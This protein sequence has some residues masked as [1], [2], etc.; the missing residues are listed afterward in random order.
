MTDTETINL[1]LLISG[2]IVDSLFVDSYRANKYN[3]KKTSF[4]KLGEVA[5]R[6]QTDRRAN[7]QSGYTINPGMYFT[8]G[9]NITDVSVPPI[10]Q[11]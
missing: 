5:T 10:I 6:V 9:N 8:A 4:E 2:Q 1:H 3:D 7:M 11:S